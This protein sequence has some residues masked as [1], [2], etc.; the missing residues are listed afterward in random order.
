VIAL[1]EPLAR[2]REYAKA[3]YRWALKD[4]G[5]GGTSPLL[6]QCVLQAR[7]E[8]ERLSPHSGKTMEVPPAHHSGNN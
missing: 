3:R 8:L 6:K 1:E 7:R 2:E 4:L 5:F